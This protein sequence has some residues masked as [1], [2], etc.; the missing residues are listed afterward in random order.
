[1][2]LSL[3]FVLAASLWAFLPLCAR[4]ATPR[5]ELLRF[6]SPDAGFCL[7]IQDLRSHAAALRDSPFR[8]H[9]LRSP[10]GGFLRDAQ[11]FIRLSKA[12]EEFKKLLGVDWQG[13]RDDVLGDALVFAYRPGPPGKPEQEEGLIL[14]RARTDKSLANLL[15]HF[16]KIGKPPQTREYK[17]I[18]YF[19]RAEGKEESY[20]YVRGPILVFSGREDVLRQ[21]LD[22]ELQ[23][24]PETEPPITSRLRQLGLDKGLL[25]L[26]V[27][28]R[29]FDAELEAKQKAA[30]PGREGLVTFAT[31]WK[32]LESVGVALLLDRDL[33]LSFA[34]R[35]RTE[36]LPAAARRFL[37]EAGRPSDVWSRVPENALLAVGGRIDLKALFEMVDEF[38]PRETRQGLRG[39][40]NRGLGA[41]LG[42]DFIA[43]VLPQVGPDWGFF[44]TPPA[45]TDKGWVPL[46]T[47]AIRVAAGG[48]G[49]PFDQTLFGAVNAFAMLSVVGHNRANPEQPI[50][51]KTAVLGEVV[52]KYF[53][54]D[55]AFSPGMEPAFALARGYLVLASTPEAVRRFASA[56]PKPVGDD[57]FPLLRIS[58]KDWR[59]YLAQRRES[60]LAFVAAKNSLGAEEA[61][62]HFDHLLAG[63]ELL[64]RIELV[65]RTAPGQVTLSLRIRT[66]QP[67]RK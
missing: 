24:A 61:R 2:S 9:L 38:L 13:L 51:L 63:L 27:N 11:E 8:E 10:L 65:Q 7:V 40:L 57:E 26:W 1:M 39:E 48:K 41:A 37:A 34:A 36:A 43:D 19:H 67:L 44:L 6:V 62:A 45:A 52:V 50:S 4:A 46:A 30:G 18:Q 14:V 66:S 25:V 29:A 23:G 12:D 20:Y 47:F 5:D 53:T 31:Y 59:E 60:L 32:A 33:T 56:V 55:R 42:K 58:F 21:A 16:H 15:D 22:R 17:G 49:V 54:G 3:R 35:A 28:P 64:D